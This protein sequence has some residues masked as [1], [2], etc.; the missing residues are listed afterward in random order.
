MAATLLESNSHLCLRPHFFFFTLFLFL[1]FSYSLLLPHSLILPVQGKQLSVSAAL[2]DL[3]LV[4]HN[5]LIRVGDGRKTVA[6]EDDP[7][8]NVWG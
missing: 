2:N 6:A 5:D 1:P 3:A 4:Q 7:L 8:A